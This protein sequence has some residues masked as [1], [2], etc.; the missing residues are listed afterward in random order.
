MP[1][2]LYNGVLLKAGSALATSSNCCCNQNKCC[3]LGECF[4]NISDDFCTAMGGYIDTGDCGPF[5]GTT[6]TTG[7]CVCNPSTAVGARVNCC[8][9]GQVFYSGN[10]TYPDDELVLSECDC[11]AVGGT[12]YTSGP[13]TGGTGGGG[14]DFGNST[15]SPDGIVCLPDGTC[16]AVCSGCALET[17]GDVCLYKYIGGVFVAGGTC[18][19][20]CTGAVDPGT[21]NL[22]CGPGQKCQCHQI[23]FNICTGST[24]CP[25]PFPGSCVTVKRRDKA[26]YWNEPGAGNCKK[27]LYSHS[28]DSGVD[29]CGGNPS[30]CWKMCIRK[31]QCVP[32]GTT[33]PT[34]TS[35]GWSGVSGA[36][37]SSSGSSTPSTIPSCYTPPGLC[38]R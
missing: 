20:S 6:P 18:P 5:N 34:G 25:T 26:E 35:K 33:C 13:C 19:G 11:L 28:L 15:A 31:C 16:L 22:T 7:A 17:L 29:F 2:Y 37:A 24:F 8:V 12:V 10:G 30:Q 32:T 38:P 23:F 9:D 4:D 14:C 36:C 21:N 1:L 3:L 27:F